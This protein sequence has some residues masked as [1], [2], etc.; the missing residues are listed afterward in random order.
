[1]SKP[2]RRR[3][4]S[5]PRL[6]INIAIIV[7]GIAGFILQDYLNLNNEGAFILTGVFCLTAAALANFGWLAYENM[8][9]KDSR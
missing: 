6:V 7:G 1:M 9:K 3:I 4:V 8:N 5:A 2:T